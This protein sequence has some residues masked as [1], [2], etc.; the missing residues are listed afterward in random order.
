MFDKERTTGSGSAEDCDASNS[1]SD[2]ACK[3]KEESAVA[4][5]KSSQIFSHAASFQRLASD[6]F[7]LQE[8]AMVLR[9]A[10]EVRNVANP[11]RPMSSERPIL[12]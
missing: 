9:G 1:K 11:L 3:L 8:A 12:P 10:D 4:A 2:K 7:K 5:A 6:L